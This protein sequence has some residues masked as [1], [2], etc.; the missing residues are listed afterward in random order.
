MPSLLLKDSNVHLFDCFL[1][2]QSRWA[3]AILPHK[4][5]RYF[6]HWS[7]SKL[8]A[9]THFSSFFISSMNSELWFCMSCLHVMHHP[10]T[11][12]DRS[13]DIR[14][15]VW[16]YRRPLKV[17]AWGLVALDLANSSVFSQTR[18]MAQHGSRHRW[19]EVQ[20]FR[21]SCSLLKHTRI[22]RILEYQKH[23]YM[24]CILLYIYILIII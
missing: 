1:G 22:S 4:E 14:L 11:D 6:Y 21:A 7:L 18:S 12:A 20:G 15:T 24:Y 10:T 3:T 2:S 9:F 16:T 23:V 5:Y 19:G 13:P 8:F 17:G